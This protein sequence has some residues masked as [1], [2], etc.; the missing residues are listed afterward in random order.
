MIGIYQHKRPF[1][2]EKED[3]RCLSSPLGFKVCLVV[4]KVEK[5]GKKKPIA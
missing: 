4:K 2:L 1:L 3:S 5:K